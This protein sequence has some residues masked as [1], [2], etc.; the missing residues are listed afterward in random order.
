MSQA[1]GEE[2]PKRAKGQVKGEVKKHFVLWRVLRLCVATGIFVGFLLVLT[3][4]RQEIP[5]SWGR[6]LAQTQLVPQ[7]QGVLSGA[8]LG[9]CVGLGLLLLL[10]L[11]LGRVY[12]SFLCPLGIFQDLVLWGRKKL[13]WGK[14]K[15]F[16]KYA[17]AFPWVRYGVLVLG[18]IALCVGLGGVFFT[19]LDPYS[20]FGR[21]VQTFV[22]PLLAMVNN[23]LVDT[24]WFGDLFRVPVLWA[25]VGWLY[26]PL[27]GMALVVILLAATKGRL[28]CNTLCPVGALLGCLS[29]FALFRPMLDKEACVKCGKCAKS[30][31]A[32][33]IDLRQGTVDTSRCVNCF[34]C[35]SVCDERG[36]H[37][38]WA[39]GKKKDLAEERSSSCSLGV[40][41]A[42]LSSGE[43]QG[44]SELQ[45]VLKREAF[46]APISETVL[47][48]LPQT[49]R[50]AFLATSLVGAWV[51]LTSCDQHGKKEGSCP[52]MEGKK[53][54]QRCGEH[55]PETCMRKI[56]QKGPNRAIAPAGAKSVERFL[57][58]CTSCF[59]CLEACP[60]KCLRPAY[61]EYGA[62]GVLKPHLTFESA[63]CNFDCTECA[64]VCPTGAILPL[65]LKEKQ[66]VRIAR[67][68]FDKKRC[69]VTLNKDDCGACSEHCPTKALDMVALSQEMKQPQWTPGAC[70]HCK[71]CIS[72]CPKGA[73]SWQ[74][75]EAT[76]GEKT[77]VIDLK[78][79]VGCGRC[80]RQCEGGALVMKPCAWDLRIPKLTVDYCIGCGACECA[81]PVKAV[82]VSGI[83]VHE[84][85]QVLV[86]KPLESPHLTEDFPF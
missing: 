57:D 35:F 39:Y 29:R 86:E 52:C 15:V 75:A 6:A 49:S 10:T 12:C 55:C 41:G 43:K 83:A 78:K 84:E 33:C 24:G 42:N 82:V 62:K 73:I 31:R 16:F 68:T 71:E 25:Q 37:Y 40:R 45:E 50:R 30:C 47:S 77:L 3:D 19:W 46:F 5:T 26:V 53:C 17:P 54:T 66:K 72:V 2:K 11:V 76:A 81:C 67:A 32:Q 38:R 14:K 4:F 1:L 23:G 70:A 13:S 22:A 28:Y 9:A 8:G 44:G 48:G 18:M 65:S 34:D 27:I 56:R 74:K 85:A 21:G 59:L 69:I 51:S 80:A 20:Q 7:L 36:I 61:M 64:S 58:V 63:F 60:T 79:C